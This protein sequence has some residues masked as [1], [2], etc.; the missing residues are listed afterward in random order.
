MA[1]VPFQVSIAI[2]FTPAISVPVVVSFRHFLLLSREIARGL[3]T[4]LS[5][6]KI[7]PA[8]EAFWFRKSGGRRLF[9]LAN[10]RQSR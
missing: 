8:Q 4:E 6:L 10:Q 3:T 9:P 5:H 1:F 2:A 7:R